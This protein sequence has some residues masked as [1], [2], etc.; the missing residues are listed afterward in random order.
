MRSST[1][2][3]EH[4]VCY[5]LTSHESLNFLYILFS[6]SPHQ[7]LPFRRLRQTYNTCFIM[8]SSNWTMIIFSFIK[9]STSHYPSSSRL[10]LMEVTQTF[11]S[12]PPMSGRLTRWLFAS[13]LLFANGFVGIIVI[14]HLTSITTIKHYVVTYILLESYV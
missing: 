2:E 11:Y 10:T 7:I 1:I 3:K 5:Q 4:L 14:C 9:Y 13:H 6:L 8:D 12:Q